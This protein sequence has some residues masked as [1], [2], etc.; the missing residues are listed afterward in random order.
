MKKG[1]QNFKKD[2]KYVNIFWIFWMIKNPII[3]AR[4]KKNMIKKSLLIRRRKKHR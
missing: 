1:K 2:K 3:N 4:T